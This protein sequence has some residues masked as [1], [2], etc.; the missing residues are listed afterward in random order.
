MRRCR[1]VGPHSADFLRGAALYEYG[2]AWIDVSCML[3]RDLNRVCWDKLADEVSRMC[4]GK[5][6]QGTVLM[7]SRRVRIVSAFPGS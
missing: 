5:F 3:V 7:N 6:E 4:V 1:Y 2:G